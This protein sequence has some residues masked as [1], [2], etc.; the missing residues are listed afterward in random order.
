MMQAV[1][2]DNT[3]ISAMVHNVVAEGVA[4]NK[5]TIRL[6]DE[7]SICWMIVT[8]V[9]SVVSLATGPVTV[10]D[11]MDSRHSSGPLQEI[12]S[13]INNSNHFSQTDGVWGAVVE[14]SSLTSLQQLSRELKHTHRCK[15][16]RFSN[17]T[18]H[19]HNSTH[20]T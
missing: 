16:E 13:P 11:I 12:S 5:A 4:E 15:E 19:R 3:S 10:H 14:R 6:Q 1:N 20:T 8:F 7:V 2:S 18:A 17:G 9:A